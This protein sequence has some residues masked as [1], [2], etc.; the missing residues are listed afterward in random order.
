MDDLAD[1]RVTADFVLIVGNSDKLA[2]NSSAESQQKI[3]V[4]ESN[5]SGYMVIS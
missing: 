3:T 1:Y 4:D 2:I 5:R